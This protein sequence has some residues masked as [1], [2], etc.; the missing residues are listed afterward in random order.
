MPPSAAVCAPAPVASLPACTTT[1]PVYR[2]AA[3]RHLARSERDADARSFGDCKERCDFFGRD[4]D[5]IESLKLRA[6]SRARRPK[7]STLVSLVRVPR[8][9]ACPFVDDKF[10][11][12]TPANLSGIVGHGKEFP[13]AFSLCGAPMQECK[14]LDGVLLAARAK[15]LRD[16]VFRRALQVRFLRSGLLS[17]GRTEE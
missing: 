7:T 11:W 5:I 10:T 14:L 1:A 2:H 15:T 8:Q 17:T 3:S 4:S 13:F 16:F 12:D 9:P 6:A